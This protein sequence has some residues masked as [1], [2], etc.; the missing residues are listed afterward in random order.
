M[1]EEVSDRVP[2]FTVGSVPGAEQLLTTN[3]DALAADPDAA[4]V[5]GAFTL[6]GWQEEVRG[7]IENSEERLKSDW[8][9]KEAFS[10]QSLD[11]MRRY[12]LE[13]YRKDYRAK[14][15]R[16]LAGVDVI[17]PDGVAV[18]ATRVHD[19]AE[20]TSPL[21]R[22]LDGAAAN[23]RLRSGSTD[24]KTP[25]EVAVVEDDFAALQALFTVQGEG[26]EAKRPLDA[27]LV[28]VASVLET[29]RAR[30]ESGDIGSSSVQFAKALLAGAPAE[31]NSIAEACAFADRHAIGLE[32]ANLES[33]GAVR[34]LLKR[35]PEAAWAGILADAQRMLDVAWG[36]DVWNPF[37]DT[38]N[39]KYPFQSGGP[40]VPPAEFTRFFGPGGVFWN[41][42]D[43]DLA[44]FLDRDG[45]AKIV[46]DHGLVIAPETA[47]AILKAHEFRRALFASETEAGKLGLAFRVKPA[48]TTKI[49]GTAPYVRTTRLSVGETRVVYDMGLAKETKVPWPGG[50]ALESASLSVTM[51]GNEPS[52]QSFEGPWAFFRLLEKARIEA[53]S[54]TECE[55]RWRLERGGEYV[56]EVP[57]TIRAGT[58][59]HPFRPGFFT[60]DCPRQIGPAPGSPIQ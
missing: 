25:P 41:F 49:S 30:Q 42:Y 52:A 3:R 48:Q 17:P 5:P 58:V 19:L 46:F 32:G 60:F 55:A 15:N 44:P 21:V 31:K 26:D 7:R 23:L 51:D 29:L 16:F 54:D 57:Y 1:V 14:W 6:K 13:A 10:G 36:N 35:V 11:D 9:L 59:P 37:H 27:Y 45:N 39:G 24:G 43:A 28:H 18:A 40:D 20:R 33:T 34:T 50:Q 38:L 8:I 53:R 22:L 2:A 12:L 56:I 4:F 47:A